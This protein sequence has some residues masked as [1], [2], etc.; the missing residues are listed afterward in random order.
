MDELRRGVSLNRTHIPMS[1]GG[2]TLLF[3]NRGRI[4][5]Q[6]LTYSEQIMESLKL[7]FSQAYGALTPAP[8]KRHGIQIGLDDDEA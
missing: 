1:P 6:P 7:K 3:T 2:T 8:L 4:P 5:S